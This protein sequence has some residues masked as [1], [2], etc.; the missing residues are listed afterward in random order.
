MYLLDTAV[1]TELIR[2]ASDVFSKQLKSLEKSGGGISASIIS[3][4][5]LKTKINQINAPADRDI[6]ERRFERGLASFKKGHLILDIDENVA[7]E[8]SLVQ[9]IPLT[10][11]DG[12]EIGDNDRLVI[13]SALTGKKTLVT[14]WSEIYQD[15]VRDRNLSV[16]SIKK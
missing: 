7:F 3:F 1:L 15:L 8:W 5:V 13:A 14:F 4:A 6:W 11:R 9:T 12:T 10:N 16:Q 2:G